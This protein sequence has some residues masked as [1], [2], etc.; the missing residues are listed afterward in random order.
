MKISVIAVISL[1]IGFG[2][3]WLSADRSLY[4]SSLEFSDS[5]IRFN[6]ESDVVFATMN[7]RSTSKGDSAAVIRFNCQ[8]AK[9]AVRLVEPLAYDNPQKQREVARLR[10]N[11]LS[12]IES[13]SSTGKCGPQMRPNSSFKPKPLRG[14]A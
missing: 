10:D 1:A 4:L 13:L 6:A 8:R 5:M 14:S 2:I 11:A 3:G 9:S 12:L 7:I